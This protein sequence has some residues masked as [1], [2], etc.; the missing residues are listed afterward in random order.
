MQIHVQDS[1]GKV[2]LKK[3]VKRA[4]FLNKMVNID[5]FLVGMEACSGARHWAKELSKLGFEVKL[6][7]PH[8]VKKYASH[9]EERR[10]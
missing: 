10:Q 8:A 9:Q 2:L 4:N 1:K 5:T 3:R 7:D 6:M